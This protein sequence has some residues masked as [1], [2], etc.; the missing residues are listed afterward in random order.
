MEELE[1]WPGQC[2]EPTTAQYYTADYISWEPRPT[3][4]DLRTSWTY[5]QMHSQNRAHLY[6][7]DLLYSR[8]RINATELFRVL[9]SAL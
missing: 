3:S 7:R 5:R 9:L 2:S 8:K 4:L 6:V 1:Y